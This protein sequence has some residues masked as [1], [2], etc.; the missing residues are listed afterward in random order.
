[1]PTSKAH[2]TYP[3]VQR[4]QFRARVDA[5]LEELLQG[6]YKQSTDQQKMLEQDGFDLELYKRHNVETVLRICLRRG[7]DP[8]I[9]AYWA[10][11]NPK[12]C[13]E[14]GLFGAEEGWHDRMFARDL[15]QVGLTDE[16]IYATR[17]TFATELL[18][19]YFHFTLATEGPLATMVS[20]FYLESLARRTQPAWLD[21]VEQHIGT[22][23]T[24]GARA[25]LKLDEE[26]EHIELTWN[27]VMNSIETPR[28]EERFLEHLLKI[29]ALFMAYFAEVYQSTHGA[30]LDDAQQA[31]AV[32]A[33]ALRS[34]PAAFVI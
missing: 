10:T 30:E 6:Y 17:P 21:K 11:R 28:D 13:Q 34:A 14:W 2:N 32:P 26:D 16:E 18:N 15:H 29:N 24:R 5:Q 19:G 7:L 20:A 23:K 12:L 9:A 25:H 3:A 22:D 1:M 31:V 33:A 8:L 4:P 27:M